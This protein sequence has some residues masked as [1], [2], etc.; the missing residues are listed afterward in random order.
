MNKYNFDE[1]VWNKGKAEDAYES[2]KRLPAYDDGQLIY[3]NALATT[4]GVTVVNTARPLS[5]AEANSLSEKRLSSMEGRTTCEAIMLVSNPKKLKV[6]TVFRT[7][8]I[9]SKFLKTAGSLEV[10]LDKAARES[11]TLREGEIIE[12]IEITRRGMEPNMSLRYKANIETTEGKSE[13]R[14]FVGLNGHTDN[15]PWDRGY[16][17]MAEA[18]QVLTNM[19]SKTVVEAKDG[20]TKENAYVVTSRTMREDGSPLIHAVRNIVGATVEFKIVVLK[21]KAGVSH[22]GW[23]LYGWSN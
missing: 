23:L 18:R 8:K 21:V 14:Y 16:K 2:V 13:I 10:A 11:V 12:S 7:V 17:S 3:N 22:D 19:V 5:L 20:D 6:R 4:T 15:Q 9:T 1:V